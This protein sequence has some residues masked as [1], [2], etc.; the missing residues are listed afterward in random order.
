MCN[1]VRGKD[2]LEGLEP[3]V[4]DWHT[5]VCLLG[6]SVYMYMYMYM[7]MHVHVRVLC[8]YSPGF[9]TIFFVWEKDFLERQN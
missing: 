3:V 1:S 7:Y 6:V 2:R 8:I 9:H 4:E 5:K